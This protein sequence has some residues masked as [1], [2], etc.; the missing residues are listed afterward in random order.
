MEDIVLLLYRVCHIEGSVL[1]ILQGKF[2]I[3]IGGGLALS[4]LDSKATIFMW[5]DSGFKPDLVVLL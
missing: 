4:R 5:G 2:L 3:G 1:L